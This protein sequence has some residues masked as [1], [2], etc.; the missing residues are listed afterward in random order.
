MTAVLLMVTMLDTKISSLVWS[1]RFELLPSHQANTVGTFVRHLR[2]IACVVPEL[3][4]QRL[5]TISRFLLR[6]SEL[7]LQFFMS[8]VC[9]FRSCV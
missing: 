4:I 6:F 1:Y 7:L 3:N 5:R 8:C 9:V 2:S